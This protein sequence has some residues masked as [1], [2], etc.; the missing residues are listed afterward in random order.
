MTPES[1]GPRVLAWLPLPLFGAWP[2]V[3]FLSHNQDDALIY[4]GVVP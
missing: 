2:F 3:A 4:G 1:V